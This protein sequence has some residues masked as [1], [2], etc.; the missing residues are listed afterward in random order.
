MF[1][2]YD[3][4]SRGPGS[5]EGL[6]LGRQTR[7]V[8][9]AYVSGDRTAGS[10]HETQDRCGVTFPVFSLV[11]ADLVGASLTEKIIPRLTNVYGYRPD[12][13]YIDGF[14]ALCP[15]GHINSYSVVA[16]WLAGLQ[17]YCS[18][19][20]VTILGACH[21]TKTK[22]NERFTNPR[23]RIAGSVAWA[24][25]SETVIIIEPPDDTENTRL[26]VVSLLPR[27]HMEEHITLSFDDQGRLQLPDK[28]KHAESAAKF[29]LDNLEFGQAGDIIEVKELMRVAKE[30]GVGQRTFYRW[31]KGAVGEGK[32]VK[33]R[34]GEYMVPLR[35]GKGNEEREVMQ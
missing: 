35:V 32:V 12:F 33:V 7:P 28:V 11:D 30:K 21:T 19:M 4:L 23:Q 1:Q 15:G 24:G 20:G 6:F 14:T 17:R 27:N 22:E 10:V 25:F 29:L 31:L 3:A 8:K 13:I 18:R 26:R 5:P 2:L 34:N 16:G 9:W